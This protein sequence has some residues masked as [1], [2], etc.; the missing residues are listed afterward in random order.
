MKILWEIFWQDLRFGLRMLF[1]KPGLTMIAI[2]SLALCTGAN[3]ALFSILD[4]VF[5]KMLP[6]KEPE[7]LVLFCSVAQAGFSPGG[8]TG[9]VW[10]AHTG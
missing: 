4:A 1:K 3:T 10:L 5:L 8:S 7:R 6:V 2:L 9:S